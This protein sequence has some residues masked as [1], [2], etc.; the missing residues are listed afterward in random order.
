MS[1]CASERYLIETA[2][3]M[4]GTSI[5]L[6]VALLALFYMAA[7]LMKKPEYE[8]FVSIESHQLA[9]SAI[10]AASVFGAAQFSCIL[11]DNFAGGDM[12]EIGANYVNFIGTDL[13]LN[14]ILTFEGMKMFAQYW[15]S[16]TFRWGLTVWGVATPAFPSFILIERVADFLLMLITPFSAS[17]MV[18]QIILETIKGTA[19]PLVLPAGAVLRIFPPTRDAG[20]FLIAAAFGFGIV[21]PFT[22]VMHS[23]IVPDLLMAGEDNKTIGQRLEERGE[24]SLDV[25]SITESG[26]FDAESLLFEP[27]KWMTYL[28]LQ[29]LFLPA[30]SMIL[31]ISFIKGMAKFLGQKLS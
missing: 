29:A 21:Y 5:S 2:L 7:Q 9:V 8:S 20:S 30:L 6:M 28:L 3:S 16:M 27:L 18:Q 14:A 25:F 11:A 23:R 31:T 19:L 15:G 4:I 24:P 13:G 12:F 17:L 1:Y 10:L 26:L 22:Y